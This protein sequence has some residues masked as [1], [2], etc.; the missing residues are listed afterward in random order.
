MPQ[1]RPSLGGDLLSLAV[2]TLAFVD[3]A[4]LDTQDQPVRAWKDQRG[5]ATPSLIAPITEPPREATC[6]RR[7]AGGD[8]IPASPHREGADD[9]Q[10]RVCFSAWAVT[11]RDR[12]DRA[13]P[14]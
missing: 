11:G 6:R 13:D 9:D 10:P 8:S 5:G 4:G 3:V 12:A 1:L 2:E 7:S 14:G